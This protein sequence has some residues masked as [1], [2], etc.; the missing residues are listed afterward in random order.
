MKQAFAGRNGDL[1]SRTFVYVFVKILV[2]C[3]VKFPG[4][5]G[6]I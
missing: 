3:C 2:L 6:S 5:Y 1:W 4:V